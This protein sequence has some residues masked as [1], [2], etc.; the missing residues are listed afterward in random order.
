MVANGDKILALSDDGDLFTNRW[1]RFRIQN[2]R[3]EKVANDSWAHLAV[4]GDHVIVR[5]LRVAQGL[6]ME[7]LTDLAA[8]ADDGKQSCSSAREPI[9]C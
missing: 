3:S 8:A 7:R 4:Q 6:S 1:Q 2:S 9:G 5:D